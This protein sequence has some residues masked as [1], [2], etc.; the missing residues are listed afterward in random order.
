MTDFQFSEEQRDCLQ[1]LVNVAM[2]LASD[3]LARYLNTL[4]HL[5]VPAI[6]LV[7]TEQLPEHFADRHQ[8]QSVTM[9]S[10]GFFGDQGLRGETI[11]LYQ[12]EN[13]GVI[14]KLLGY[15]DDDSSEAEM[16]T[17]I[18][19]VLT[20][21]FLNGLAEQLDN[22]FSYAAPR[23]L[24]S[25][26]KHFAEKLA[27]TAEQWQLAL[28]V[29]IRYQLTDYSFNCDMILLIPGEAV[30]RLRLILDQILASF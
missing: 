25:R 7:K 11:M 17:D 27:S 20:T 15:S 5:Q 23:I 16:L 3:K 12:L 30:L 10:L 6:K 2:G 28:Q 24:S 4:V 19:S 14:A 18:S 22:S 21:T 1:E 29:D 26:D 9:I 13:V 8:Q